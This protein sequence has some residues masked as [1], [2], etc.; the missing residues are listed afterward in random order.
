MKVSNQ[1]PAVLSPVYKANIT[2]DFEPDK[3]LK[4]TM[5]A[6]LFNPLIAGQPVV[7]S[8]GNGTI[9]DD[10]IAESILGCC[11]GTVNATA[12]TVTKEVFGKTLTYFDKNTTLPILNTFS[13][14]AS[15]K[16]K[17]PAPTP[18]VVYTPATDVIPVSKEFL[19]GVCDYEKYFATLAFYARPQTLGFYFANENAFDGFKA[20]LNTQIATINATLPAQSNQ[21]FQDFNANITLKGLTESLV[22]RNTDGENNDEGS[23]ARTI[24][25]Y[26]MNYANQV[27]SA[28]FGV[29]PFDIGELFCPK[30]VVFVNVEKHAH[31]T[32]RQVADEWNL[33]NQSIAMKVKMIANNKLA[34]LTAS[35]RNIKKIQGMAANAA[36]NAN[37]QATRAA[38]AKFRHTAPNNIDIAKLISRIMNKMSTVAKSENTYKSIKMTY[39]KPNR[40]DPDD[41]NKQ[42]KIVSTKYKPDL[43]VYVDTSGSISEE[44]YQDSIK[45]LIQMAR[46]LNVNLYFNSFSHVLSQCTKLNTRD[47][48]AKQVYAEFQKVPKVS[49]GTDYEQIWHYINKSK[50]RTRELSLIITDMEYYAPNHYVKHPKNVYYVPCS[51]MNWKYIT[52]SAQ[53]FVDSMKSIDPNCR[54][55]LLF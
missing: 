11:G 32:A 35:A 6:P 13:I 23:F 2:G 36:S 47:K 54:A 45:A 17:L 1:K 31:A 29:L 5:V 7:M 33:I 3:Y 28:E 52:R 8:G 15:I 18:S 48:S 39:Q 25:A 49:G 40:R 50:K 20:W 44:N 34:K 38:R 46:K 53:S 24:I 41:F 22:I 12:E 9:T 51:R 14:Q 26:L 27:S 21:M 37:S 42:G 16:E 4:Q 30:T 43:H 19:S 10:D 55:R